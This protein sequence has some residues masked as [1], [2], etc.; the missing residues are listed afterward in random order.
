VGIDPMDDASGESLS[1]RTFRGAAWSLAAQAIT[2]VA[3]LITFVIMSR[4]VGHAELGEYMLAVAGLAAVQW[5]ALNAYREPVIQTPELTPAMCN[6]AFWFSAGI[7]VLLATVLTAVAYVLRSNAIFT[8]T[9]AC[10]SVLAAKAFFDAMSSIPL[11]LYYRGLRFPLAAKLNMLASTAGLAV[12]IG[13]LHA[14]WGVLAVATAQSVVSAIGFVLVLACGEWR[15]QWRFSP[16]DLGFLRLYSPHVVLWQGVEALNLYLDRFI[17]GARLSPQV[18]G[19]Y[20]FGRRLNDVVIE[21]LAGA[22]GNV[23]LPAY[24]KVQQDTGALKRA[25]LA[26]MRIVTFAVFPV[27]GILYGVADELVVAVFGTKWN[28]AV[29]IYK[30]FLLL[31]AIQTVG[32]LQASLIRSLGRPDLWA[33]Y[34]LMQ[35]A[36]NIAVL[37]LVIDYGIY[38]LAVAVV[39]RTYLVWSYAVATTCR[40]LKMGVV[41]YLQMFVRPALGAV[42]ACIVAQSVLHLTYD[43]PVVVMIAGASLAA[44]AVYLGTALVTMRS[45]TN[46]VLALIARQA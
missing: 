41:E 39:L 11:A 8:T 42:L 18:L 22:A 23:A 35:A 15:P 37:I 25:Y 12:S 16:K 21:M 36:A 2:A 24:S 38:V 1:R 14:G 28:A 3:A 45:I 9:A 10:L 19:V 32:I 5:L 29:P 46:D 13:L 40:L 20:G 17:V 4:S 43:I 27:I 7:A 33:R 34:Q 44:A 31:G 30:C 26:S 6:S